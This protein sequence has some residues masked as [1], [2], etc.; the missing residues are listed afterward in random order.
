MSTAVP[1]EFRASRIAGRGLFTAAPIAAGA[2]VP[3]E[4]GSLNHS[5]EPNI[6]WTATGELVAMRDIAADEELLTDYA[7]HDDDPGFV[8]MC[9]CETY[10]CRQVIEGT[11]WQIPQLQ[12]RYA[13]F[14]A[15]AVRRRIEDA[16]R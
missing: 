12:K 8:L 9:H 4:V 11:D 7:L 3:V 2:T 15:P 10:R 1:V 5:C 6:G 13:G 16:S 14:W